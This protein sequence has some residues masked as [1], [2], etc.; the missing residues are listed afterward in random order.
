MYAC[1]VIIETP[2]FTRR[3]VDLLD[4]ASYQNSN[5]WSRE[6][7]PQARSFADRAEFERDDLTAD[8][9]RELKRALIFE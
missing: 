8:Q 5:V 1:V 9:L 3:V 4:D 7:R 6:I 2:T